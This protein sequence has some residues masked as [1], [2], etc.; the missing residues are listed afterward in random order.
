LRGWKENK[1]AEMGHTDPLHCIVGLKAHFSHW[2]GLTE[3]LELPI[4]HIKSRN[5]KEPHR[6]PWGLLDH[7][8]T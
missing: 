3:S 5:L 6:R 1:E 7:E 4:D 8:L 2:C